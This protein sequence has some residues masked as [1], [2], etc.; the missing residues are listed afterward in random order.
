MEKIQKIEMIRGQNW[1]GEES[2][3]INIEDRG[4]IRFHLSNGKRVDVDLYERIPGT[5]NVRT[6][7]QMRILMDA[8]NCVRIEPT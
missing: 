7:N 5:L 4:Y 2:E 1:P 3:E 8:A 6:M